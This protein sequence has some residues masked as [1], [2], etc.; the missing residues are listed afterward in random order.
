MTD[1]KGPD[2]PL[3]AE[4]LRT[5]HAYLQGEAVDVGSPAGKD[6]RLI[7]T[8]RVSVSTLGRAALGLPVKR[9]SLGH[10][11]QAIDATTRAK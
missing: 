6:G 11:E 5:L 9:A 8:F 7:L 1:I 10:L 3:S 4:R 2:A